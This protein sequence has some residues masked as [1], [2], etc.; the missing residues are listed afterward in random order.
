MSDRSRD[1]FAQAER[2]LE[3]AEKDVADGYYEHACFE[4]Q[5]AAEKAVKA[6]FQCLHM[7]AWGNR[8]SKL[9]QELT[10]T[11]KTPSKDLIDDGKLIDQYY[12]PTRYPNGFESGA[13]MDY[14][15]EE[16]ADDA[17][18]RAKKIIGWCED[19]LG[20]KSGKGP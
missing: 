17:V 11:E 5:Q 7:E 4:A 18:G 1:W 12:I 19:I 20:F 15:T 16:Q 10:G 13:P 14:Y 9:L 2:D 3:H 8:V 6:V